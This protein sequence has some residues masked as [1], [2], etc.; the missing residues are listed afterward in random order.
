MEKPILTK[1]LVFAALVVLLGGCQIFAA[2]SGDKSPAAPGKQEEALPGSKVTLDVAAKSAEIIA[3]AT[4]IRASVHDP[5]APG[6]ADYTAEIEITRLLK[7]ETKE[8]K[9]SLDYRVRSIPDKEEAPKVGS[10]YI[11]FLRGL[12][13]QGMEVLKILADTEANRAAVGAAAWGEAA[14]KEDVR[15][16]PTVTPPPPAPQ[17]ASVPPPAPQPEEPQANSEEPQTGPLVIAEYRIEDFFIRRDWSS[18]SLGL[19]DVLN[20]NKEPNYLGQNPPGALRALRGLFGGAGPRDESIDWQE[21]WLRGSIRLIDIIKRTVKNQ[22]DP[23]VAAWS[24]EGGPASIDYSSYGGAGVL[25]VLQTREG[26][27]RVESLLEAMRGASEVGGPMLTI[28]VQW[29]EMADA[30]AAELLGCDPAKRQVPMEVTAADLA[31]AD[32]KT[33]YRGCTT[34]FDR[35]TVFVASGNLKAYLADGTPLVCAASLGITPIIRNFL[36]GGM[37]EVRPQLS[38][39]K[40]AVLLDYRSYVNPAATIEHTGPQEYAAGAA[41]GAPLREGVIAVD[42]GFPAVDF[43]TLRG[44]VRI[45]LGKSIL[46]GFTTGPKLKDG[47]VSCLIV[48][49]SASKAETRP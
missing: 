2:N 9:L 38:K 5:T 42:F 26:Q 30:K 23:K 44:S 46:L 13:P 40:D 15:A 10:S 49:V 31:K 35:Q 41:R 22:I 8:K 28:H 24:D 18:S 4:I 16:G 6:A 47:K 20:S 14:K 25:I 12:K 19:P 36:V 45:P 37:L 17:S 21:R 1:A 29:V 39:D 34:C 11:F 3:V 43:Q 7:G 32:A 33:I 48:E 27:K